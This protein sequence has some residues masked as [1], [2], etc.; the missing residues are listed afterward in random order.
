MRQNVIDWLY[1]PTTLDKKLINVISKE[2]EILYCFVYSLETT[3]KNTVACKFDDL[4]TIRK[5]CACLNGELERLKLHNLLDHVVFT[6]T[7]PSLPSMPIHRDYY[8]QNVVCFG[9]N[10]PVKNCENSFIVWYDAE[11]MSNSKMPNYSLGT[12]GVAQAIP[13]DE[14]SAKELARMTCDQPYWVNNFVPHNGIALHSKTRIMSSIRFLPEINDLVK[15]GYFDK[16]LT[17]Y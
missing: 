13:A 11:L 2:L 7:S 1:K 16:F 14:T 9:L 17:K 10:I 12:Q 4:Q 5:F 15:N 3:Q 6:T 8:D